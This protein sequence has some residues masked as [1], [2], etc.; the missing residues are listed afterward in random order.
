MPYAGTYL[1]YPFINSCNHKSI[2]YSK[3][4]PHC[5]LSAYRL[6]LSVTDRD[7]HVDSR[8]Q[9]A[10]NGIRTRWCGS[11]RIP[12]AAARQAGAR[13][14]LRLRK[15]EFAATPK[16]W[17]NRSQIWRMIWIRH[18]NPVSFRLAHSMRLTWIR[19]LHRL[20]NPSTRR[21]SVRIIPAGFR[22][23]SEKKADRICFLAFCYASAYFCM[24]PLISAIGSPWTI[25][26]AKTAG[27]PLVE[28]HVH[29][30]M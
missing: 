6:P 3:H 20:R 30:L 21:F 14:L 22:I 16:D 19:L 4:F 7:F 26:P 23:P 15:T 17:P 1:L 5:L 11:I 12:A 18:K 9:R 13:R 10:G 27:N 24:V 28:H 29:S 25:V 2:H 8:A